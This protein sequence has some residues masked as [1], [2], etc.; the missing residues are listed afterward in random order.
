MK[1]VTNGY[2]H[3]NET[4]V[5]GILVTLYNTGTPLEGLRPFKGLTEL[6]VYKFFS[7]KGLNTQYFN[8][9]NEIP[10]A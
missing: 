4:A 3:Y 10:C 9:D 5:P 7:V 1:K 6:H 8:R 2:A